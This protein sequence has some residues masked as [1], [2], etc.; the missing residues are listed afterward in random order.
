MKKV[1]INI[2]PEQEDTLK[3]IGVDAVALKDYLQGQIN[4]LV[5]SHANNIKT[6]R[7]DKMIKK[8]DQLS[9][10]DAKIKAALTALGVVD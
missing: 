7:R 10:S 2:T 1:E 3:D 6:V 8:F 4:T 5:S 9:A